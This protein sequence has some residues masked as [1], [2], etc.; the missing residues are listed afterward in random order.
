MWSSALKSS[1]GI[2]A[3]RDINP[4]NRSGAQVSSAAIW[5][6]AAVSGAALITGCTNV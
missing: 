1:S 5:S 6:Q 4:M 3:K 2:A